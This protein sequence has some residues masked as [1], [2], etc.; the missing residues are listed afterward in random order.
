MA[1]PVM[2]ATGQRA[3]GVFKTDLQ[4]KQFFEAVT[5]SHLGKSDHTMLASSDGTLIFCPIFLIRN[6]TLRPELMQ[7]IF[8]DNPGWAITRADVHY[9][10]RNSINGFAPVPTMSDIHPA[11]F[12]GKR[13]Y[14]FTSQNPT[15]T[16]AP[17][18]TLMNWILLTG[19]SGI[20]LL[21]FL[22]LRAANY[23]VR[24]LQDLR[25]GVKLIGF[26]NL[27]HRL[28]IQT[29]DEI[30]E[31]ADE[32]NE[33]ALK[34]QMSYTSL[35][36]KVAERTKE[37][38]VVNK[39]TR[40]IS[41]KLSITE[42]FDSICDEVNR[43]L[44]YDRIS[45]VLLD[46]NQQQI[47]LRLTKTKNVPT[48][49]HDRPQPKT[50]TVIGRVVDS[51]KPFIRAD[52]LGADEFVEDQLIKDE[53][54]RS[55]IVVPIISQN[56]SIGTLNLASRQPRTYVDRNLEI[57]IPI[58]E[59]LAIAAE[60]IRLFEQTKKLDQL[61]SD[62]VSK[63]S[64]ELRTPLTSIKGFAEIL[65]SYQDIDLKTRQE[66]LSIINE[67]SERL[68]R[69]INDILDISKIES[70]KTEWHIQPLSPS[71]IV[72]HAVKSV[73]AMALEKN[74]PIVI[75][76]PESLPKIRGDRDQLIQVLDNLLGNAIKFSNRGHITIQ[77][78]QEERTVRISVIDT[79]IGIPEADL[80][81]IFDKF[82][83]LGNTRSGKPRGTGLGLS[84]CREIIH[85]L[86]GK[87]WCESHSGEGSRF[88]F[89]VPLWTETSPNHPTNNQ[90]PA[91]SGGRDPDKIKSAGDA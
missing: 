57:L 8:K 22:G 12:N 10:G 58:A 50:G 43:L 54:L 46:D 11:S 41:S 25:E 28:K 47:A 4:I 34:L 55:Y 29:G 45:L 66:F 9:S 68:T 85:H 35:E 5:H 82:H 63:V 33:M 36:Q 7:T 13:W 71:E 32:F 56:Q 26:G 61:K 37:L 19:G 62:F 15:E 74:L 76:V 1:V 86:G 90:R 65:L 23:V 59:Q 87:I 84:I 52:V 49:V 39:I 40:T 21:L 18:S 42:I 91:A 89:T 16:Y 30:Q 78:V 2:E 31:L 77:G 44:N 24:P 64:H 72:V 27:N 83:H 88:H 60:T 48:V 69:L 51:Q 17:I 75:D 20:V 81:K 67:E 70:G 80:Q 79:G 14:I 38:E 73:R 3:I 6:H 53:G